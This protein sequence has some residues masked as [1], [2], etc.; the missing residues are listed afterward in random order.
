[1]GDGNQ[2]KQ[3]DKEKKK[4]KTGG[5]EKEQKKNLLVLTRQMLQAS[6]KPFIPF[7][8]RRRDSYKSF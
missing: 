5:R 2:T 4:K 8:T 1:M 7:S 6:P 3:I